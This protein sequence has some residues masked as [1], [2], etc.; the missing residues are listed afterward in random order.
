L[1][2]RFGPSPTTKGTS[3]LARS[4]G[5]SIL[6]P[7][8][9][10]ALE[11][12]FKLFIKYGWA[13]LVTKRLQKIRAEVEV[14]FINLAVVLYNFMD[15]IDLV[16]SIFF[17]ISAFFGLFFLHL[18]SRWDGLVYLYLII[19]I[20]SGV[21][22]NRLFSLGDMGSASKTWSL[23]VGFYLVT[24]FAFLT[25][26]CEVQSRGYLCTGAVFAGFALT[27]VIALLALENRS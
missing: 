21:A 6:D 4:A 11:M 23:T 7:V 26:V 12:N 10:V 27:A 5:P 24:I 19:F 9:M 18:E 15:K 17:P 2:G 13:Y 14:R 22:V 16:L 1:R 25:F 8:N 3:D 20:F